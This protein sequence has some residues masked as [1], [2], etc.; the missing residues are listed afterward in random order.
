MP[1]PRREVRLG[2]VVLGPALPRVVADTGLSV[3]FAAGLGAPPFEAC[4]D[5]EAEDDE[6]LTRREGA[7]GGRAMTAS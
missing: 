5:E 3:G 6:P 1:P 4:D 7:R 2:T